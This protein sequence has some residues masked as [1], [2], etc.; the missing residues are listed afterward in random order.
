MPLREDVKHFLITHCLPVMP[1]G[2]LPCF[3]GYINPHTKTK[4][5]A[6]P[7]YMGGPWYD[8]A[9]IKWY[10]Y[11]DPVP[12]RIR[13]FVDISSMVPGTSIDIPE[14]NQYGIGPGLYAVIESFNRILDGN[15][16][17]PEEDNAEYSNTLIGR[18][19]RDEVEDGTGKPI[20]YLVEVGSLV[21]SIV[22]MP[23]RSDRQ[24]HLDHMKQK[25]QYLFLLHHRKDWPMCWESVIRT[26]DATREAASSSEEEDE[27]NNAE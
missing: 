1:S 16:E 17:N 4:F 11:P 22:G 3:T 20:L 24:S 6:H 5:R 9:L 8:C 23:N 13:A 18:Y 12:A 19:E 14:A 27:I 21:D 2:R 26:T 7:N 15:Q 10:E 25:L